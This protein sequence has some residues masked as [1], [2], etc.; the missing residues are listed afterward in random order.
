RAQAADPGADRAPDPGRVGRDV[1][2]GVGDRLRRR[3]DG[4]L[5]EAVRL[6]D[7]LP[8]HVLERVEALHLAGDVRRALRHHEF[9]DAG[10]ARPPGADALPGLVDRVAA[11]GDPT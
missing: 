9:L 8:V 1:E 2:V 10:D 4:E 6:P 11:R 5:R 3:G 7:R